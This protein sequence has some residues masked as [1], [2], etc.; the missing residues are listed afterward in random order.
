MGHKGS[1]FPVFS[2]VINNRTGL[3]ECCANN[4]DLFRK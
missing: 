4:F 3:I 2:N 1:P